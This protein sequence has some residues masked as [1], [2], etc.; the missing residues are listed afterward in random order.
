[1]QDTPVFEAREKAC[2]FT[3]YDGILVAKHVFVCS[4]KDFSKTGDAIDLQLR[5]NVSSVDIDPLN[6]VPFKSA[7][8]FL[9][10]LCSTLEFRVFTRLEMFFSKSGDAIFK[11]LLQV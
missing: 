11:L 10:N 7:L 3:S 2:P 1:V 5:Q 9:T 6:A 8:Q 4:N